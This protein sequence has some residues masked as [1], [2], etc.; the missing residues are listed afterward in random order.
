MA[1]RTCSARSRAA[2]LRSGKLLGE[3]LRWRLPRRCFLRSL[4]RFMPC[5]LRVESRMGLR[6]NRNASKHFGAIKE[7]SWVTENSFGAISGKQSRR[8]PLLGTLLCLTRFWTYM[9]K[10]ANATKKLGRPLAL[11]SGE[12][13]KRYEGLK[14]FLEHNWGRIGLDLQKVRDP[15]RVRT[16]LKMVPGVEWCIPFR[17]N[18]PLA[19]LLNDT[20][21]EANSHTVSLARQQ[22]EETMK[23]E[24]RLSTESYAA[25]QRADEINNALKITIAPLGDTIRFPPFFCIAA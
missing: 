22:F 13:V 11:K 12:L 14:S 19:C 16:I 1:A 18:S 3:R 20:N 9:S 10:P 7:F 15:E 4:R 23:L 24:S 21:T 8:N 2:S 6:T 17:E 25:R 5:P